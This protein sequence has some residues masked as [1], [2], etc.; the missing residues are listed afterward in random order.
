MPQSRSVRL[1]VMLPLIAG[2]ILFTDTAVRAVAPT[3]PTDLT[4]VVDGPD[5][6]LTWA[7]S[8]N[9]PTQYT[10]Q[11]GL[12]PGQSLVSF[13]LSAAVTTVSVTAPPGT[14]YVRVVAS[15]SDGSS[16]PSSEIVVV[17]GC[18]PGSVKNV[19]VMQRGA[20]AFLSW[21]PSGGASSYAVQAGFTPG[22]TALQF[23]LPS[24]TFNVIV[25]P[26][27]YYARVVPLN[28][29]GGGTPTPDVIVNAPSNSVRAADPA[30]GTVL[31]LP[32]IQQLVVR[33]AAMNPPTLDN[34][35]PNRR[36]Y[37]EPN[38]WLNY[39]VDSLR[40]YDTRFGYNAKPTRREEEEGYPIIAAGDEITYFAGAG[41]AQGSPLVYAI[42]ILFNHC[43]VED[44][45]QP[46]VTFRN[47]APEPANWTGA[48]RFSG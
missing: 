2:A 38:P 39:M 8:V 27:A 28:G 40:A 32:D 20:E 31:S 47:I 15:N 13:P 29:C 21:N 14:Y 11:A 4:A 33:L 1:F 18:Q 44:G 30:P 10:V 16:A 17:V 7:P 3:A 19:R 35:C 45:G 43:D 48:G 5:V 37:G 6:T 46:S 23:N 22:E 24:N 42:D 34:S 25:P 41:A 36:K 9:G 26:G 12:V